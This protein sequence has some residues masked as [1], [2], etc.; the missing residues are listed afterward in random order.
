ML[1]LRVRAMTVALF[2]S[3]DATQREKER[4]SSTQSVSME[5]KHKLGLCLNY[6][7][8]ESLALCVSV[9]S[10]EKYTKT[11]T[12]APLLCRCVFVRMRALLLS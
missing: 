12:Q 2:V 1:H 6:R 11:C 8:S 4:E 5:D 7:H 3:G 9:V 10:A